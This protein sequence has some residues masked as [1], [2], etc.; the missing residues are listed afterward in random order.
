MKNNTIYQNNRIYQRSKTFSK[1]RFFVS[2]N[3]FFDGEKV[4]GLTPVLNLVNVRT[5]LLGEPFSKCIRDRSYTPHRCVYQ[6]MLLKIAQIC[7]CYPYYIED[8]MLGI[9]YC[10]TQIIYYI[11]AVFQKRLDFLQ[12][13]G[14]IKNCH[15]MLKICQTFTKK[16]PKIV[17]KF[18]NISK[19]V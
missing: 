15:K 5:Q 19:H 2:R 3:R 14:S 11:D 17:N 8:G 1:F 13:S 12:N 9:L 18:P 4:P 16:L 10:S 7:E 6:K